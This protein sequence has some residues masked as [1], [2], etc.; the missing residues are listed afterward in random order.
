MSGFNSSSSNQNILQ[1]ILDRLNDAQI[2][3]DDVLERV[4]QQLAMIN[5][6]L[7]LEPGERH[8]DS[9]SG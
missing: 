8:Y 9:D 1:E 4:Q 5:E 3:N 7:S 6:D 2:S